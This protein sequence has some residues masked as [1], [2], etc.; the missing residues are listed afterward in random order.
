MRIADRIGLHRAQPESLGGV[1][2]RLLHAAIV[3]NQRLGLA[4]FEEKLA[5]VGAFEAAGEVAAEPGA[6]EAGAVDE[7]GGGGLGHGRSDAMTP[8]RE[9]R[10]GEAGR[11][12]RPSGGRKS[13]SGKR[14]RTTDLWPL[15]TAACRIRRRIP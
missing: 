14:P 13:A 9:G 12:I 10:C 8:A 4:I 2:G 1:I 5:V 15:A 11:G 3:E 7:R 6:V